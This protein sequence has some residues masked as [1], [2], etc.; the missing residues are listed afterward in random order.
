[1]T[2]R[3]RITF[4]PLDAQDLDQDEAYF[5]LMEE[6]D[7][8]KLLFHDYA[9]DPPIAM[10]PMRYLSVGGW[11]LTHGEG[12]SNRF[13]PSSNC[14]PQHVFAT[15]GDRLANTRSNQAVPQMTASSRTM[16]RASAC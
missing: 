4:P 3:H 16:S 12:S 5:Y 14:F 10:F 9:A 6:E 1:M 15:M 2:V 7:R 11:Y 13:G 8:H